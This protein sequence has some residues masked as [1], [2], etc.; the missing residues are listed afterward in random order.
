MNKKKQSKRNIIVGILL[1]FVLLI[2]GVGVWGYRLAWA[3]NFMPQ[4]TVYIYIGKDKSFTDLCRQLQDSADCSRIGSF[5]QLA[6]MLKYQ[7]N[8]RTGRYAVSPGMSNLQLL[9]DLR[10]GHQVATRL[11]FNNIRFKEDLAERLDE[12]LMLDKDEL[13]SLLNDSGYCDSLGFTTETI[14]SLFIPN[15]YEVYWNIP[16][17]K[18]MQRMKRE[19]IAFW[20]DARLEKAKAIGLTPAEVAT[21]ASIVEEETA[22]SD[23]YPIVAGLY[24]NRLHRGIPLQADPTVKFAVGDFTLQR[25]LFEHLEVN[26]PYNTYKHA[27]LP[28]GPLR[29]PTI[30]GMDSVLNYMKHNY[31]YM[32]AKEDFSGRHNFAAT[33]AEHNRNANRYRAELN[34]RKIR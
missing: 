16:A 7:A 23:E 20:T 29:I 8:I 33:L 22:V 28:P 18:L 4:E 31:L 11:T 14:T 6:G 25:I 3:P 17:D 24:L 15:T 2:A 5:K 30:K 32:C 10:R 12:Q 19:Y 9:N 1:F 34:R 13:L 27:G 26:S 21:L